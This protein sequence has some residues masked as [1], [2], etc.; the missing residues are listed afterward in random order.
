[1]TLTLPRLQAA[2][3]I[4]APGPT[5]GEA[6]PPSPTLLRWWNA[7]C[8]AIE[9]AVNGLAAQQLQIDQVLG[10]ATG[11]ASTASSA[12]SSAANA[13][14]LASQSSNM[15]F[16]QTQTVTV[17]NTTT[18]TA[19]SGTGV[20][21]LTL[22]ANF[23]QAGSSVRVWT[24]GFHSAAAGATIR[25]RVYLGATVILDTGANASGNATNLTWEAR[26][27]FTCRAAGS[28]GAVNAQGYYLEQGAAVALYGMPNTANVAIDTTVTQTVRVTAQWGTAAVGD[29]ISCAYLTLEA[30][31]PRGS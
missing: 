31:V 23:L 27:A 3:P 5:T 22:P 14:L 18:E 1:M 28:S 16:A 25:I 30:N 9:G 15:L 7:V 13:A 4:T 19:I 17:G 21:S 11:A 2:A 24:M 20:G 12:A 10:I 6:L 8:L 29:T 26:A